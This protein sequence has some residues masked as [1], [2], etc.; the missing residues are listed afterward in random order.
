MAP[1]C[2]EDGFEGKKLVSDI[3]GIKIKDEPTKEETVGSLSF[4]VIDRS[5]PKQVSSSS[6][7]VAPGNTRKKP[8]SRAK[9]PFEKGYSQMD[10]LKLT[11]THPDLAGADIFCYTIFCSIPI[12]SHLMSAD[13]MLV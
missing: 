12:Q 9:V 2:D 13:H 8:A 11:R 3:G 10:W 6:S 7:T 1:P 5:A 4:N